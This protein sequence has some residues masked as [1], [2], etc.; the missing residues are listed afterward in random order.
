[1]DM[2]ALKTNINTGCLSEKNLE[3]QFQLQLELLPAIHGGCDQFWCHEQQQWPTHKESYSTLKNFPKNILTGL[4]YRTCIYE[5]ISGPF[6]SE[7]TDKKAQLTWCFCCNHVSDHFWVK[8]VC[9]VA[10]IHTCLHMHSIKLSRWYNRYIWQAVMKVANA[11][12]L[13]KERQTS[14]ESEQ[15]KVTANK[16]TTYTLH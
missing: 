2:L 16:F 8:S 11:G 4:L 1:M 13:S 5:Y 3:R 9:A 10:H 6:A 15:S 12:L 7:W 14:F